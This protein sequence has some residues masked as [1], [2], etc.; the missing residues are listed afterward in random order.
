MQ[1]NSE[2]ER[3][4]TT[5]E[6]VEV[7]T[8]ESGGFSVNPKTDCPHINHYLANEEC[9]MNFVRRLLNLCDLNKQGECVN[10][11]E[12]LENWLCFD[13]GECFCSRYR[14][15]H[16]VAHAAEAMTTRERNVEDGSLLDPS[17]TVVSHSCAMSLSDGSFWCFECEDYIFSPAL[18]AIS[19]ASQIVKFSDIRSASSEFSEAISLAE[20]LASVGVDSNP[21]TVEK[22]I[23][24][25]RD[26]S[27][28]KI[29]FLTGAGISVASG[30]PDFRTPGTGLYAK[31]A[32]LG[33]PKPEL[34]FDLAYFR[35]KPETFYSLAGSLLFHDAKP[36]KAHQFIKKMADEGL[37][38]K[39]FTQNIDGLELDVGLDPTLL[40]QAHG[41]MRNALCCEC[42]A[43]V[44]SEL[45]LRHLKEEKVLR[46][47]LEGCAGVVKPSVTFFGEPLPKDFFEQFSIIDD[48]D[49]VF[50]MGTSL[51]VQPFALLVEMVPLTTPIVLINRENTSIHRKNF[52]FLEGDIED[53]VQM[54]C[55]NLK[56]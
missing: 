17:N 38:M 13:C 43:P 51:K 15:G 9:L 33:L 14:H 40:V 1:D 41:H 26:K 5:A 22:L 56:Y 20:S 24:G 19:R 21:F 29:V 18:R 53:S 39:C 52:L 44:D 25:M 2:N 36:V 27:F 23:E 37:L 34:I 50:V 47:S 28:K 32:E 30:I 8:A 48:A 4:D 45:F 10:C 42:R 31:V 49:L 16:M 12:S 11:A 6:G 35:E 46:C 7:E 3:E 55:D 54:I